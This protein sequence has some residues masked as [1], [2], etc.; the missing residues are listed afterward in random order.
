MKLAL[1]RVIESLITGD[2]QVVAGWNVR[3]KTQT[4]L[5]DLI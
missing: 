1:S 5:E 2:I 4:L 3:V